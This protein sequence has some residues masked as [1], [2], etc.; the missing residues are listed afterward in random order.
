M[1]CHMGNKELLGGAGVEKPTETSRMGT[2]AEST[3]VCFAKCRYGFGW[4]FS[5]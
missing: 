3:L 5:T 2:L 1:F 4:D